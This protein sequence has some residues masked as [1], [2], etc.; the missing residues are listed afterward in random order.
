MIR[1]DRKI[2]YFFQEKLALFTTNDDHNGRNCIINHSGG[3]GKISNGVTPKLRT[4]LKTSR[5]MGPETVAVPIM[6]P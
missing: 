1:L 2:H 3:G 5:V 4:Y 6:S